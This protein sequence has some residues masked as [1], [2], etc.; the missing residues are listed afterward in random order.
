MLILGE[1]QVRGKEKRRE[2]HKKIYM[3]DDYFKGG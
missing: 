3:V 2:R 1:L